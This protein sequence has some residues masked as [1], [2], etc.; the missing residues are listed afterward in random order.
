MITL[1]FEQF[2]H[3]I[4]ALRGELDK[5]LLR[6]LPKIIGKEAKDL[7]TQNFANEAWGRK[8][9]PEVK[10]RQSGTKANAW[11][12]KHSPAS[13]TRRILTGHTGDLGRSIEYN[14]QTGKVSVTSELIYAAVHNYGLKAGRGSGFTM[15]QRQFIGNDPELI[16][17]VHATVNDKLNKLFTT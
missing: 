14:A 3:K 13:T 8:A 7:F 15:P 6:D 10:R 4:H 5:L 17:K 11:A 1:T 16:E 12:R 9:W 2:Q